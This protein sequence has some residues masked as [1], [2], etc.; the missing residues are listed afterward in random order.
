MQ[1]SAIWFREKPTQSVAKQKKETG[2]T[3]QNL[4]G[5]LQKNKSGS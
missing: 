2:R 3:N 4:N 5:S 1:A